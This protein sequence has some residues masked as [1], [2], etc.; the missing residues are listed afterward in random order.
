MK[1]ML[2]CLSIL[3]LFQCS[4]ALATEYLFHVSCQDKRLVAQWS[5]GSIDP[6]REYLRVA[7]G[8]NFPSCPITDYEDGRD[9]DLPREHYEYATGVVAG[10][11]FVGRIVCK[12]FGC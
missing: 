11:P 10:I 3:A 8:T 4:Q 12:W 6:G 9:K 7:T 2:S 5:T 1:L